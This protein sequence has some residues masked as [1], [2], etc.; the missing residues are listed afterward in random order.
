MKII[1]LKNLGI[2]VIMLAEIWLPVITRTL[3]LIP[4]YNA[5]FKNR[6]NQ[7]YGG[8]AVY[9]KDSYTCIALQ[10]YSNHLTEPFE[11][12]FREIT[13]VP[14]VIKTILGSI[15]R[16][17]SSNLNEFVA[18]IDNLLSHANKQKPTCLLEDF[19]ID[20]LESKNNQPTLAIY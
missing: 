4:G 16:P 1:K 3:Y 15:Y 12:I 11:S 5:F 7:A 9:V 14:L 8:I 2:D 18:R 17:P 19:N 13:N 10:D 6:I 20:F